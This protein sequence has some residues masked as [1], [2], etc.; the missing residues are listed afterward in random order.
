MGPLGRN[1]PSNFDHVTAA[2][3]S[4]LAAAPVDVPVSIGT[5][6][7]T[8]FDAP[9]QVSDGSWHLPDAKSNLGT[10][11]GGHCTVLAPMGYFKY[12]SPTIRASLWRWYNQGQEGACEGF[13]HAHAQSILRAGACFDA[14]WLYDQARKREGTYPSGEGTTN[15]AVCEVLE[16]IGLRQSTAPVAEREVDDG[17]VE[18]S[19]GI[20]AVAW[21][22]TAEEVCNALGRPNAQAVPLLNS[23]GEDYPETVWLP[24]DTLDR[25]LQEEGEADVV[26]ERT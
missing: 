23:W 5:N 7:Y 2:P 14:F 9:T 4:E 6:W 16:Q 13:G 11:R 25:L 24:V 1:T 26:T 15:R 21:A 22:T 8:S 18:T 20:S 10:V 19:L 12:A 3:I 17:P